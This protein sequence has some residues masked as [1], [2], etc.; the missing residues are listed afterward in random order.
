MSVRKRTWVSPEGE[1]KEAWVVDYADQGGNR[2]NKQF[3]RKRDAEAYHARVAVALSAGVHTP[4][5]QSPTVS[6]AGAMASSRPA[7]TSPLQRRCAPSSPSSMD[8]GGRSC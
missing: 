8:D 5:S 7:T 3:S 2:R 6:R 4:E 1:P